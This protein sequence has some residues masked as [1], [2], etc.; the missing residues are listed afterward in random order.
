MAEVL[1]S[2]GQFMLPELAKQFLLAGNAIFTIR[3]KAT[4]K[5]FTYKIYKAAAPAPGKDQIWWCNLLCGPDNSNDY[6]Y[7]GFLAQYPQG[8]YGYHHGRPSKAC[9]ACSAD[10]VKGFYYVVMNIIHKNR[11][12]DD[13]ELWHE[14]ACGRC[15]RRLTRPESIESGFG[16]ECVQHIGG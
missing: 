1:E 13:I 14:G 15:G 12:P 5:R 2:A 16:P 3:S 9:A 4:G 8:F 11:I 10:S 7:F 6:K